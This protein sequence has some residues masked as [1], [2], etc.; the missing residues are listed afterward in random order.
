MREGGVRDLKR[1]G[2]Y[3]EI[4]R[5][6]FIYGIGINPEP[7]IELT[8][9]LVPAAC[10]KCGANVEIP[11]SLKKAHCVYCGAEILIDSPATALSVAATN[12]FQVAKEHYKNNLLEKAEEA[13]E[14][15]HEMDPSNEEIQNF[16]KELHKKQGDRDWEELLSLK[17]SINRYLR[18]YKA[19]LSGMAMSYAISG[20]TGGQGLS[21]ST[22]SDISKMGEK[23]EIVEKSMAKH[24]VIAGLCPKCGGRLYCQCM[25]TKDK[26]G[27]HGKEKCIYCKGITVCKCVQEKSTCPKCKSQCSWIPQYKQWYC[28]SC[29][30]YLPEK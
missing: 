13:I 11:E 5:I 3:H 29:E 20:S 17:D 10:P 28:Y 6:Y 16:R 19:Q 22:S 14:R 30:D 21:K 24:Y 26:E 12:L 23:R 7:R 25:F 9:K 8:I 1:R 4:S 27:R 2:K 15:A 18:L